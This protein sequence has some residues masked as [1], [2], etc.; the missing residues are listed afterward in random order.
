MTIPAGATVDP[1]NIGAVYHLGLG[2][3][4]AGGELT[5]AGY[6][7]VNGTQ[8][9]QKTD[10]K[11]QSQLIQASPQITDRD[12]ATWPRETVGDVSG[13][14][15]QQIWLET[16]KYYDADLEIRTP[17]S[18]TLRPANNRKV[19]P[20]LGALDADG[21]IQAVTFNGD[22]VVSFHEASGNIYNS[23]GTFTAPIPV[24]AM[25]TDS[26]VL[27][28]S[29]LD[30]SLRYTTDLTAY[31]TVTP[32]SSSIPFP[33][34]MTQIWAVNQGTGGR[35]VYWTQNVV[36]GAATFGRIDMGSLANVALPTA[37]L[38]L[39]V[40]DLCEYGSG[41]AM[42]TN[43]S[44]GSPGSNVW[45]H[46]GNNMQ[47]IL[48]LNGYLCNGICNCLGN[49][50]LT[51]TPTTQFDAP[52]LLQISGGSFNVVA[53]LGIPSET[54]TA[55]TLGGPTASGQYI[56]FTQNP[57]TIAGVSSAP[58][59][60][61][62]D[63]LNQSLSHIGN[64]AATDVV[65]TGLRSV[66]FIGRAVIYP[67]SPS[68]G[69]GQVQYQSNQSKYTP[70]PAYAPSGQLCSSRIDFNTPGIGKL[71]RRVIAHHSPLTAGQSI[72][73]QAY[74]DADPTKWVS[75][76]TPTGSVTN[77]TVGTVTTTLSLP[78]HTT[79]FSMFFV[80]TLTAG[81]AQSTTPIVY[82]TSM[83]IAVPWS[84]EFTVDCTNKRQVLG[85]NPDP[86]NYL[87]GDLKLLL[88]QA[89]ENALPL[90]LIHPDGTQYTTEIQNLEA[91]AYSPQRQVN[92]PLRAADLEWHVKLTLS[93]SIV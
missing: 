14:G 19:F 56:G 17:G 89:W 71:F 70:T 35:F 9:V 52:V 39:A 79:G 16:H 60:W 21:T 75:S 78:T 69:V 25:D 29:D 63:V 20:T 93:E 5:S 81:A 44:N 30:G 6:M 41:V 28:I 88:S 13:G 59:V 15:L 62:Y 8:F 42:A 37:A 68:A 82:Y 77:S 61:V 26:G 90:T 40:A 91:T 46:D 49:L 50:F 55:S 22:V 11:A 38:N 18:L 84:W 27:F 47:L 54:A 65:T 33:N 31:T 67:G 86:Q 10:V 66:A 43:D 2:T 92:T 45:Y 1:A 83:E 48:R 34:P 24:N 87:G 51:A 32:A 85:N 57:P 4:T 76:A 72:Q 58:Y 80:I 23:T 12:L 53:T 73:L 3:T 36:G 64:G 74:V 7:L